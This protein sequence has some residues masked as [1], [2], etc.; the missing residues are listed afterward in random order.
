MTAEKPAF[1]GQ[2][3][4]T[5]L[6]FDPQGHFL[7]KNRQ[8][9]QLIRMD[10]DSL[11]VIQNCTLDNSLRGHAIAAFEGEWVFNL[12]VDGRVRRYE[13]PDVLGVG[14][15][16]GPAAMTGQ[17]IWP[18]L[19]VSFDSFAFMT[20]PSCQLTGGHFGYGPEPLVAIIAVAV[21]S[22]NIGEYP[23]LDPDIEPD[24]LDGA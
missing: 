10:D 24:V 15:A 16:W 23:D 17:G 3:Q 13:G 7:G 9:R 14:M 21:E 5:E 6:I 20:A 8:E 22:Q 12:K 19:G 18:R 11:E 1:I 4:V 2:W